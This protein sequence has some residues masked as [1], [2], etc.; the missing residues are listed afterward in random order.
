[1]GELFDP[2]VLH[3]NCYDKFY[4]SCFFR[5]RVLSYGELL[6]LPSCTTLS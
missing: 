3:P 2:V 4:A 6:V 5:C 1:M